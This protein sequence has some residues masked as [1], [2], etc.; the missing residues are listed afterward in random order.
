MNQNGPMPS[1]QQRVKYRQQAQREID[2]LLTPQPPRSPVKP[3]TPPV[4][5]KP[6][7]PKGAG[8]AGGRMRTPGTPSSM[9]GS[10]RPNSKG[11]AKGGK[12]EVN[13]G[14]TVGCDAYQTALLDTQTDWTLDATRAT[15]PCRLHTLASLRYYQV[16]TL[17]DALQEQFASAT[18]AELER[19]Q[20][21]NRRQQA[22]RE[23]E[24]MH[25][26]PQA[27]CSCL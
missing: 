9:A 10:S 19:L 15:T 7:T 25:V 21:A 16:E 12:Q 26:S 8:A 2:T 3:S 17:K 11:S 22:T 18:Q 24:T 5:G 23:V 4:D 13:F 20:E 14:D 1:P 27:R 6:R